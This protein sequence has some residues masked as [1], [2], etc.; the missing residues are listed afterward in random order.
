MNQLLKNKIVVNTLWITIGMVVELLIALFFGMAIT[1]YL[2][3]QDSGLFN[4]G[5]FI[6]AIYVPVATL[7]SGGVIIANLVKQPEREH[8]I[9]GTMLVFRLISGMLSAILLILTMVMLGGNNPL[10]LAIGLMQAVALLFNVYEMFSCCFNYKLQAKKYVILRIITTA[11]VCLYKGL[12]LYFQKEVLWFCFSNVLDCILISVL[13]F[14][15]YQ[16]ELKQ[17]LAF[18]FPLGITI[19]KESSFYIFSGLFSILVLQIDKIL[20][21]KMMPEESL[22]LYSMAYYIGTLWGFVLN[23]II[24]SSR[25]TIAKVKLEN[26]SLFSKRMQQLFSAVFFSG[27]AVALVMTF[28]SRFILTTL[29]GVK[30]AP[31]ALALSVVCW[32][33]VFQYLAKARNVWLISEQKNQYELIFSIIGIVLSFTLNLLL[34]PVWGIVG[35]SVTSV[36]VQIAIS[37]LL[38][39]CFSKTRKSAYDAFGGILLSWYF[40]KS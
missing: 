2:S 30:Y 8:E 40:K 11:F 7:S 14:F 25:S 26:E 3:V 36:A 4:F 37:I 24:E 15:V 31:A 34:I 19:L 23:A 39:F 35:S 29:Y 16:R 38:P 1:Q 18:S 9:V 27:T 5:L 13:A 28:F 12:I 10:Y 17:R 21:Q 33:T 22:G 32:S 6:L 20:I